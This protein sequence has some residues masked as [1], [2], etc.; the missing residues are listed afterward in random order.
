MNQKNW[1]QIGVIAAW[2]VGV[3]E[4]I[5]DA[6][7]GS[8]YPG[9]NWMTQSI[10]YLGQADSPVLLEVAIWGIFF[11][12]FYLLFAFG[13]YKA[14]G[15]INRWAVLASWMI[16]IYGLGEGM[17]SGFSPINPPGTPYT[18]AAFFHDLLG[19]I[20]DVAM[21]LLPLV[22]LKIFPRKESSKLF[23]FSILVTIVGI[24]LSLFFLYAKAQQPDD[25]F[26]VYKGLIQ[27]LYL[28]NYIIYF[29]AIAQKMRTSI[30]R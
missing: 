4:F 18:T 28:L 21:V 29:L 2:L 13:F 23:Y 30:N 10:S 3:G 6:I 25:G 5:V 22:V 20:G 17:G 7:I 12:F 16:A 8:R 24:L 11:S 14:F 19:G 27:R 1:I 9:Y 26:L 15:G